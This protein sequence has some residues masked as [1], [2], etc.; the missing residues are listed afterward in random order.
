MLLPR[1]KDVA[2]CYSPAFKVIKTKQQL[3]ET[4]TFPQL[5]IEVTICAASRAIRIAFPLDKT[6]MKIQVIV[7]ADSV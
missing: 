3:L 7:S 6:G 4:F 2:V 5:S 1:E